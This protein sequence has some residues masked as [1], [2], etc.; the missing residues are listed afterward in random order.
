MVSAVF[1]SSFHLLHRLSVKQTA[2]NERN[3]QILR[4]N[5][6]P[7]DLKTTPAKEIHYTIRKANERKHAKK[8]KRK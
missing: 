7:P 1:F 5:E 6:M 3:M 8:C 4:V 2:V